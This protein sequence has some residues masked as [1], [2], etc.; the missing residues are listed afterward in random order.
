[1]FQI[2]AERLIKLLPI[3]SPMLRL[4]AGAVVV[5]LAISLGMVAVLSLLGFEVNPAL[6]SALAVIG[7]GIFAARMKDKI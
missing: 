4:I 6:P 7:A 2:L 1:M 3:R 5:A